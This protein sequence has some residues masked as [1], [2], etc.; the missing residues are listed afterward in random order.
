M[1]A[2][3]MA[4]REQLAAYMIL[5]RDATQCLVHH[6]ADSSMYA[7]NGE[8]DDHIKCE[9]Q[10]KLEF[11]IIVYNFNY[12]AGYPAPPVDPSMSIDAFKWWNPSLVIL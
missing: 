8:F 7:A 10:G 4:F 11:S 6:S 2:M 9:R 3:T 1:Y 5:N 12:A